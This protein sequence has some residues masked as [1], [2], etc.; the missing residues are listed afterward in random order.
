[1]NP[2][3]TLALVAL[4][5]FSAIIEG[6]PQSFAIDWF[7]IDAGGG[8]SEGGGYS[9]NG[10]IAQSDAGSAMS[11]GS[12]SMTGDFWSIVAV[13]TPEAPLL[14]ILGTATN[15]VMV[16]WPSVSAPFTLQQN[17]QSEASTWS[18]ATQTVFDDGT[19]KY[20]FVNPPTGKRFYRLFRSN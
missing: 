4:A 14:K 9:V 12:Y 11:G 6:L 19:N 8:V 20:I 16:S 15:T 18:P 5:L 10:S 7:T 13:Q 3:K 1:M 2:I 17:N